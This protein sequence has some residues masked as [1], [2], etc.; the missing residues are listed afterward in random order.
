MNAIHRRLCQSADWKGKLECTTSLPRRSR[1]SYL[2]KY[3]GSCA[4]AVCSPAPIT[5]V[6]PFRLIHIG[7]T[8]VTVDP[9]TLGQRL[10]AVGFVNI[11][12]DRL[13]QPFRFRPIRQPD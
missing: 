7:D 9:A 13:G 2:P 4:P 11:R 12:F 5:P 6:V 1:T 3:T 10:A 8:M